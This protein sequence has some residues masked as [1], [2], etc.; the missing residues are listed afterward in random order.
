MTRFRIT[1]CVAAA[2]LVSSALFG[3]PTAE[4]LD[5]GIIAPAGPQERIEDPTSATGFR[6]HGD[7]TFTSH[8]IVV[9]ATQ[10]MAFG[11]SFRV[12]GI[13]ASET[14]YTQKV[15]SPPLKKPDGTV[16]TEQVSYQQLANN[17]GT[18]YG[19]LYYTLRE[20]YEVVPGEWTL[21]IYMGPNQLVSQKFFVRSS[22]TKPQ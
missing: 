18:I 1:L 6:W 13:P 8:T 22:A 11:I 19:K 15:T 12:D 16:V 17:H 4:I 21:A 7:G 3:A 14:R 2:V 20:S 5:A 10:G 9:P